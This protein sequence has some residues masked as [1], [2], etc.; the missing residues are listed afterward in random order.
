M[1]TVVWRRDVSPALST[2][3]DRMSTENVGKLTKNGRI[4][5][6]NLDTGDRGHYICEAKWYSGN[7]TFKHLV[8][9]KSRY[10]NC[11]TEYNRSS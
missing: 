9:V 10:F 3:G 7:A 8:R 1:S 5:L 6:T 2:I 4:T 11:F